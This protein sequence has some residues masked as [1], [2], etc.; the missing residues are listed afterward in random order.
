MM[1]QLQFLQ[2]SLLNYLFMILELSIRG[3]K[4]QIIEYFGWTM[5]LNFS[6][7]I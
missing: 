3:H 7:R 2:G 6:G 4:W 1:N 5:K